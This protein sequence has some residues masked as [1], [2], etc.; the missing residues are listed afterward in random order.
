M[1]S[2][3]HHLPSSTSLTNSSFLFFVCPSQA[4][5]RKLGDEMVDER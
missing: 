5:T 4:E 2:S 1:V 3:N